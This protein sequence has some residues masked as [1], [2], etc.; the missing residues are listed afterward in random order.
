MVAKPQ[1]VADV[2]TIDPIVVRVDASLEEA[3]L[4]LRSAY[5]RGIPVVDGDGAL[6]GVLSHA[7]LAAYRFAYRQASIERTGSDARR[8]AGELPR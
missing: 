3:D 6:V 5:I 4:L 2:M 1:V 8:A 7:Q